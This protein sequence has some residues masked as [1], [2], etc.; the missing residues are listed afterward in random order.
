MKKLHHLFTLLLLGLSLPLSTQA[1]EKRYIS[2]E[3]SAYI[4]SGPSVEN[5]IIGSLNSGE[6]VT[7]LSPKAKNGFVQVIDHKG[8][9]SWILSNELSDIPSLRERI[10]AMEQKIKTLT[11]KLTNIDDEWNK[12]TAELQNK[13][14]NSDQIINDLKKENAQLQ[15]KLTVAEKKVEIANLQLDDRQREIILQWFTYGGGVAGIGLILGLL[16]P[17]IIPRRKNK[18]RWMS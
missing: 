18:D 7:L 12:R 13:V 2:D 5:R 3:L 6:E 4:R 11:D 15:N 8:R 1:E 9:T 17:R 10:P 16:L 14:A